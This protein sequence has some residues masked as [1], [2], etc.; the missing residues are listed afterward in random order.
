MAI[1]ESKGK[2][3]HCRLEGRDLSHIDTQKKLHGRGTDISAAARYVCAFL[4]NKRNKRAYVY[5]EG[6]CNCSHIDDAPHADAIA[7]AFE[8][9]E[10]S[11]QWFNKAEQPLIYQ[12]TLFPL[13]GDDGTVHDVLGLVKTLDYI[14]DY[15]GSL[16]VAEN[17]GQSFVRLVIN[18]REEGKRKVSSALHDEIGTAAVVINSL[19][20]ILKEDI[21]EGKTPAALDDIEHISEALELSV[22]RI[23]Q[24]IIDL[25]PPQLADIGLNSAVKNLVDTLSN[26]V[27]LKINYRYNIED[28]VEMS[29]TVKITLY[30]IVQE[31]VTNTLKHAKAKKID[32]KFSENESS[33]LLNIKD[34]GVGY[35]VARNKSVDKLGILGMKENLSYIG[36][37]MQIRG[38]K[39][40]GTAIQV[41]CPK[42]T[43][44]R[45]L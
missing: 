26:T 20:G 1:Y 6:R 21:K 24:V 35:A 16:S 15:E 22:A 23:K 2:R 45:T 5:G 13:A 12:T 42:I 32:I 29:E 8:G 27:P 34:D 18:A 11:Y 43:Y 25:R 41:S 33:I 44:V 37:S 30:R 40:K 39:G 7:K 19:L 31:A 14:T 38:V 3:L 28:S 17:P 4:L 9:N 36:G 10:V